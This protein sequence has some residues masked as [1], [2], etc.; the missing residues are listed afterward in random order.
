MGKCSA[1]VHA[2]E[3]WRNAYVWYEGIGTRFQGLSWRTFGQMEMTKESVPRCG[4]QLLWFDTRAKFSTMSNKGTINQNNTFG[5]VFLKS[6]YSSS[7]FIY[8]IKHQKSKI[9]SSSVISKLRCR[10]SNE[11]QMRSHSSVN[12]WHSISATCAPWGETNQPISIASN[13]SAAK[14][15]RTYTSV[16]WTIC[17][18]RTRVNSSAQITHVLDAGCSRH[19]G[20]MLE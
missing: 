17:A 15:A 6:S 20:R 13:Q 12:I 7:F 18:Y 10:P 11:I 19:C 14:I 8:F 2:I 5:W 4:F 1:D 3:V 9:E 16:S